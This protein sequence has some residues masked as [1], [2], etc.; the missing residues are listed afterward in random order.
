MLDHF[1]IEPH[2]VTTAEELAKFFERDAA[3]G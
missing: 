3:A 2:P 1:H